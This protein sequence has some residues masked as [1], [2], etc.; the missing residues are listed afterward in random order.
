MSIPI[1]CAIALAFSVGTW[2]T[3]RHTWESGPL[4]SHVAR[5]VLVTVVAGAVWPGVL[6]L[7]A[8][9]LYPT[10][11]HAIRRFVFGKD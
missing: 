8:L 6:V 5:A 10:P 7:L 2:G 3:T 1:Y 4:R 11:R 9:Y